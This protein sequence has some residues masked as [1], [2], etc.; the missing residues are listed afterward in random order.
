[1]ASMTWAL[2]MILHERMKQRY[3]DRSMS[4]EY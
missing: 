4:M 3:M 2:G 1:M